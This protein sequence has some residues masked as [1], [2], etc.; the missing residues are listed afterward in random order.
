MF[1]KCLSNKD[2]VFN[3]FVRSFCMLPIVTI[4]SILYTDYSIEVVVVFS[5]FS[6]APQICFY[7]DTIG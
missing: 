2:F 7:L 4:G 3:A 6:V 1:A 5:I